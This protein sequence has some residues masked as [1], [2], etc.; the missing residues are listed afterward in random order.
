MNIPAKAPHVRRE[1]ACLGGRAASGGH[2]R[3][4]L[5]LDNMTKV[6]SV[7]CLGQTHHLLSHGGHRTES[8]D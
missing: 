4:V 5:F 6:D 2:W 1:R 7:G 3:L 8:V